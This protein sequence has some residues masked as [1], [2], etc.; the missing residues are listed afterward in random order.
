MVMTRVTDYHYITS[1]LP[2]QYITGAL[3]QHINFEEVHHT[4]RNQE[5]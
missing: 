5:M 1:L 2:D 3:E 4:D